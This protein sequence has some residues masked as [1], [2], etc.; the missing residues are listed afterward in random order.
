M[1]VT[2]IGVT[3]H[4]TVTTIGVTGHMTVTTIGVTGHNCLT[5]HMTVTDGWMVINT[6]KLLARDR[7]QVPMAP[8]YETY[9]V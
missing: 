2:T 8:D 9:T 7:L 6:V 5:G 1:T 3:G 4:M